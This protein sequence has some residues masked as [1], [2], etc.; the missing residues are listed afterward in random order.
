M[1]DFRSVVFKN[2]ENRDELVDFVKTHVD[3]NGGRFIEIDSDKWATYLKW[4]DGPTI[5]EIK[6]FIREWKDVI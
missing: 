6:D 3:W 5:D 4:Y 1:L 2:T